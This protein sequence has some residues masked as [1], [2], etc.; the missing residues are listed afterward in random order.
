MKKSVGTGSLMLFTLL[1]SPA[2]A[3]AENASLTAHGSVHSLA[4]RSKTVALDQTDKPTLIV[5]FDE[6]TTFKNVPS[7][8][9]ILPGENLTIEYRHEGDDNLATR[10]TRVIPN[11]PQGVANVTLK[12]LEGLVAAGNK[13][14]SYL[15][16]DARPASK[17]AAG[18]IPTAISI[19]LA[20]LEKEGA[21][22]LPSHKGTTLVFY[23]GGVSCPLS[24][25]SAKIARSLGYGKVKVYT[26]GE[27]EWIKAEHYTIPTTT[28]LKEGN[29]VLVD[30]RDP[31][32][33]AGGHIPGA[34][35]VPLAQL[36]GWEK[37][38]PSTKGAQLVFYGDK[39]S[40]VAAAISTARD[41]GFT[42]VTGFP[43]GTAE[44]EKSGLALSKDVA[45]DR[46]DYRKKRGP[47]EMGPSEFLEEI[48]K[49]TILVDVRTPE[50]YAK[51]R[52]AKAINIPAEQMAKRFTELP[53]GKELVFYC[54][55]GSRAEMAYDVV[56]G[57]DYSV[58]FLNANVQFE[59][60]G[61]YSVSE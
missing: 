35:N 41:W 25:Q 45:P 5:R 31:K 37:K 56:R 39:E 42:N 21:K 30:L 28:F 55:T 22:L 43:G 40:D 17:Y 34:I 16:I 6:K 54:N 53:K 52:I 1:F 8:K 24:H 46:I 33:A 48:G 13:G 29:I 26:G 38:F 11:L 61:S 3:G 14:G 60:D 50:E 47:N 32:A 19:P 4:N 20:T 15:L 44:W 18:H 51:E 23:C 58:K 59:E 2:L 49:G 12:E 10:I 7:A 36:D 27:P 57:K 9:D